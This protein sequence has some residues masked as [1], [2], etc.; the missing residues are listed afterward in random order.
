MFNLFCA[1]LKVYAQV[2]D[3]NPKKIL[4]IF[5][6]SM[7]HQKWKC[8][9][10]ICQAKWDNLIGKYPPLCCISS[11]VLVFRLA[12]NLIAATFTFLRFTYTQHFP[13][14]LCTMKI[15]NTQGVCSQLP[16]AY[17]YPLESYLQ[18]IIV[19]VWALSAW[20]HITS[21]GNSVLANARLNSFEAFIC[22]SKDIS[23]L[24]QSGNEV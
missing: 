13:F 19:G 17:L 14:F 24:L 10:G 21:H 5:L 23:I 15:G 11:L 7:A 4:E 18:C 1:I 9:W 16:S 20:L 2:I 6:E 3:I 12:K 8:S 22:P